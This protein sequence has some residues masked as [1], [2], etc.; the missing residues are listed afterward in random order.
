MS[1]R[2]QKCIKLFKGGI[3]KTSKGAVLILINYKIHF[4][5]LIFQVKRGIS[6]PKGRHH[7]TI[8]VR[9]L[10]VMPSHFPGKPSLQLVR[11]NSNFMPVPKCKCGGEQLPSADDIH[12]STAFP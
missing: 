4:F 5:F 2:V 10:A 11:I 8:E 3:G 7:Q 1:L 9:D 6:K 12:C